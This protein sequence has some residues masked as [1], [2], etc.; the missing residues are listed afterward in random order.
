MQSTVNMTQSKMFLLPNSQ[1]AV[2]GIQN[3]RIQGGIVH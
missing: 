2:I 1:V 3:I